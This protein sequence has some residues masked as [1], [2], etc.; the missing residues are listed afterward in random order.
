MTEPAAKALL[1]DAFGPLLDG[2]IAMTGKPRDTAVI[3]LAEDVG[4]VLPSFAIA[5]RQAT[6]NPNTYVYFFDQV[7]VDSRA[8]SNRA[9]VRIGKRLSSKNVVL[10]NVSYLNLKELQMICR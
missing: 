5:D 1:G 6:A 9:R 4:F 2:Y 10:E 8:G 7:P 3:D